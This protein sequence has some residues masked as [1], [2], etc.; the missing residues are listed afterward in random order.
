VLKATPRPGYEPPNNEAKVLTGMEG[1]LWIDE[2]TFQ[3]VK[4][5]PRSYDRFRLKVFWLKS[6]RVHTS[7][8]RR[9]L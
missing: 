1:K 3:W 7:N 2:K 6:N 9:H 5:K 8:S 4:S